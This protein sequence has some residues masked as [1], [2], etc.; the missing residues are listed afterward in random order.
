MK[1]ALLE[2]IEQTQLKET[3]PSFKIGDSVRVHVKIREGEKE[4]VQVY[5]GTVIARDGGGANETFTVRRVSFGE[6]VERVFP[7]H[8]PYVVKV[9]VERSGRIRRAKLYYLRKRTGKSSRLKE[10]RG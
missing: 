5:A 8:S 6:G 7:L 2:K 9:E 10:V 3:V 4:R 1:K